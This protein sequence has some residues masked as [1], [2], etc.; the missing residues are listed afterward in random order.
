LIIDYNNIGFTYE[1]IKWIL[2]LI[3]YHL[4]TLLSLF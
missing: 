1:E 2:H 3:M 4:N